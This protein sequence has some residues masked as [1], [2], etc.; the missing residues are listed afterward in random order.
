MSLIESLLNLLF[1]P[2]CPVCKAIVEHKGDFCENCLKKLS[3]VR[4]L[5]TMS[6][7]VRQIVSVAP[8][9]GGVRELIIDIKFNKRKEKA[10][11]ARNLLNEYDSAIPAYPKGIQA[12]Y[13]PI[14]KKR[15]RERGFNQVEL[16]FK[17]WLKMRNIEVLGALVRIKDTKP[18]FKLSPKERKA[19]IDGA[20]E[21]LG[22]ARGKDILLLDDIFTTGATVYECAKTL[23]EHGANDIFV[24]TLSS[25]K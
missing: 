7:D 3:K 10:S 16:I 11:S 4:F 13:V 23:K 9:E 21:V 20:F 6:K 5:K 2:K 19:N 17:D 22:D 18:Q 15:L 24:L 25:N 1:P 8:Y 12:V 14:S